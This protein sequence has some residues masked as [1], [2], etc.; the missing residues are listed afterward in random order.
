MVINQ[1]HC[2]RYNVI[3]FLNS[4]YAAKHLT[5]NNLRYLV[6][7]GFPKHLPSDFLLAILKNSF[8]VSKSPNS[9]ET[10]PAINSLS[11][12]SI[13]ANPVKNI[14]SAHSFAFLNHLP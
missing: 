13:R 14:L 6:F 1:A 9:K 12:E 7:F 2:L 10:F 8:A 4:F 5:F 3:S 11:P